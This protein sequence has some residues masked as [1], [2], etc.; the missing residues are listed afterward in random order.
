MS[1]NKRIICLCLLGC[2]LIGG[3]VFS[4]FYKQSTPKVSIV[5]PTYNRAYFLPRLLDSLFT[6]TYQDF[7]IVVVD[8]ASSDK[9]QAV[10]KKYKALYPDKFTIIKH[11]TNKGVSAARNTGN[12][13]AKGK[14]IVVMDSDDYAM[15]DML[16]EEVS[17]MEQNPTVDLGI[18]VKSGYWENKENPLE[19]PWTFGWHY[20]AYDFMEGNHLGNVGNIFRRDFVVKHKISYNEKYRCAEDYDFWIQMILNGAQIAKIKTEKALVV[21]RG[22]GELSVN[23]LACIRVVSTVQKALYNK[24]NYSPNEKGFNYCEA[25][26]AFLK[27]Y[28]N[29]FLEKQKEEYLT[30]CPLPGREVLWTQHSNWRDYLMF[31]EMGTKV[32]RLQS[33]DEAK[34]L[35]YIP[36]ELITIKWD[37]FGT[38]TF[39]YDRKKKMYIFSAP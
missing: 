26:K 37:Y 17:F 29:A 11:D 19:K 35:S 6:Q 22:L 23:N 3:S 38:E 24:I 15:P 31:D 7:E 4:F 36:N 27:V 13:F 25:L 12:L 28:P 14:Y 32:Q 2:F 33:K 9:T 8:D 10:L 30:I 20:P 39:V 21:F 1:K 34:V 16:E 18:P 5:I